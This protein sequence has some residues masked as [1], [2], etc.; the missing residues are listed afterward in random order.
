MPYSI[1]AGED[2]SLDLLHELKKSDQQKNNFQK[3][4][5]IIGEEIEDGLRILKENRLLRQAQ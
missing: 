5:E 1:D 4:Q 2:T 3:I